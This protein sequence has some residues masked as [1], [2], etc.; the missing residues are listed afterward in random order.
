M[1]KS[2]SRI[3]ICLMLYSLLAGCEELILGPEESADAGHVFD[4]LWDDFDKHYA[5][6]T[7]R[8]T[9]WDSLYSAYRPTVNK[10]T[11]SIRLKSV[12]IELL[13]RLDDSHV[14]L[15]GPDDSWTYTS[16]FAVGTI[17][18]RDEFSLNLIKNNYLDSFAK[19]QGEN[20]LSFGKI[21]NRNIG[22]IFLREEN[23]HDPEGAIA[24]VLKQLGEHDAIILDLRTN[25]GGSAIY[26]RI[27]AGAFSDGVHL[28]GTTQTRNGPGYNDFDAKTDI[29]T[30]ITGS[31]QYHKPVV[32]LTDRATISA[33][34]FLA[35]HMK[36]FSQVTHIGDKTAGDFS[37][38]SARKFLPNGWSYHYS[39]Q[40]FLLPDGSSLDG[41]GVTPDIYAKNEKYDIDSGRDKVLERALKFLYD[42]YGIQ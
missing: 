34:E 21:R 28:I 20:D 6:F 39:V 5:L 25:S 42:A 1:V 29:T 15:Y 12:L 27:I 17:A 23:G 36:S 22:Y 31:K 32:V 4:L 26:S 33:G 35:L 2:F 40:M 16:G 14:A 41:V 30:Q 18:L 11:P 37:A 19:V 10:Y 38:K 8:H 9:N 7:V 3:L 24:G 13:G